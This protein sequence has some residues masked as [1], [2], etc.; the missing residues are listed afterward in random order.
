MPNKLQKTKSKDVNLLKSVHGNKLYDPTQLPEWIPPHSEEWYLQ[1]GK[2]VGKYEYPW[3]SIFEGK[4]AE[5]IF[6]ETIGKYINSNSKI[7]DVGCG[8]GEFT[9]NFSRIAKNVVGIDLRGDFINKANERNVFNNTDFL[10]VNAEDPLPLKDKTFDLVYTKKGPWLHKEASRIL[11]TGGIIIG[12]FH[13]GTDGGLRALFP[14]LYK[15]LPRDPYDFGKLEAY[16]K[17]EESKGL[18]NFRIQVIE[19]IEYL[20]TPDDLLNKKCF[21]QTKAVKEIVWDKCFKDVSNIFE[22]N[23]SEKGL[24]VINYHHIVSAKAI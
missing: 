2:E 20:S 4:K 16:Y 13:S 12:L 9:N 23:A 11:K 22:K 21:G 3:N 24:K 7:L 8:H 19:E 6:K 14:G 15:P 10:V 5:E 18:S 17:F 1:L